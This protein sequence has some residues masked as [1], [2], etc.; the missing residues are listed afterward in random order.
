[1]PCRFIG[2]FQCT[3]WLLYR[4][5]HELELVGI[6]NHDFQQGVRELSSFNFLLQFNEFTWTHPLFYSAEGTTVWRIQLCAT[7]VTLEGNL[8]WTAPSSCQLEVYFTFPNRCFVHLIYCIWRDINFRAIKTLHN[9]DSSLNK[10]DR[11]Y[12]KV[13]Q[14]CDILP[15][16]YLVIRTQ[17][18]SYSIVFVLRVFPFDHNRH[19]LFVYR[20]KISS[21]FLYSHQEGCLELTF[22]T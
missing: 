5:W 20:W 18:L 6:K 10:R 14:C 9:M 22:V 13:M 19:L 11:T 8:L 3:T 2:I 4:G 21:E 12:L 16:F 7:I 15:H 17:K 1:M